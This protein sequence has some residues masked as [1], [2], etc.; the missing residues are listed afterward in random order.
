[1]DLLVHTFVGHKVS[2]ITRKSIDPLRKNLTGREE[3][4]GAGVGIIVYIIIIMFALFQI[5]NGVICIITL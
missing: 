3:L 4:G 2:H 5:V 1:M